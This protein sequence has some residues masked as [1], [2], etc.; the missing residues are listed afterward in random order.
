MVPSISNV[1]WKPT[2]LNREEG[3]K[4]QRVGSHDFHRRM[5]TMTKKPRET[6]SGAGGR[7]ARLGAC[8]ES[9]H[10]QPPLPQATL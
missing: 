6:R 9:S 5:M 10:F 3:G 1:E 7:G 8:L 2:V 4:D